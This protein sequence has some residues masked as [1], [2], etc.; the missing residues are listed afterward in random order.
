MYWIEES[1]MFQTIN[2]FFAKSQEPTNH[3]PQAAMTSALPEYDV[4]VV[5]AGM[6]GLAAC[7]FLRQAGRRVVCIEPEPFPHA[8]VG[9]SLDW[10][11]PALL[12]KLGLSQEQLVDEQMATYKRK[13]KVSFLGEGLF[14]KEPSHSQPTCHVD[15]A[16]LDQK[17]FEIAQNMGVTFIWQRI[18]TV[19]TRDDRVMACQTTT[20]QRITATWF[21]D[22]SGRAQLFAKA[23]EIPKQEYG[24]RKVCLWTYFESES[25]LDGTTLHGENT[26]QYLSWIW[27]IP[28][29]PQKVSVGY[30]TR[31]DELREQRK[32]GQSVRQ[33]LRSALLS[34]QRFIP[35][36]AEQPD[37]QVSVCSYRCYV[38][39][40]ACGA[41]WF[42]VGE[43]A[44]MLDP[45]T[46]N[47]VTAALRHAKAATTFIRE[48]C[49]TLSRQEQYLYNTNIRQLGHAFNRNIETALYDWPLRWVLGPSKA[50]AVYV[51]FGYFTN[52]LYSK[53]E[54]QSR[55]GLALFRGWL[56]A[57]WLWIASCSL[58]A[59]LVFVSRQLWHGKRKGRPIPL[60][61]L[62][63]R[64]R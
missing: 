25:H 17:L 29:T 18:S 34:H 13:I 28:I 48:A 38:N 41:N 52:V 56:M 51:V 33:I 4:A 20:G 35:L 7:I 16:H 10:S 3:A 59:R 64:Q 62:K 27:E 47:G 21:I 60:T 24:P 36:L 45:M 9:E 53:F 44:S 37:Y 26:D 63:N 49:G 50:V 15:R 19:D 55:L 11:A 30:I 1:Q 14:I 43:A 5:G 22:A 39:Q 32:S 8:R 31:A 2:H 58:I 23:F 6:G 42:M 12:Q 54:P 57:M 40:Y 46:A 61:N